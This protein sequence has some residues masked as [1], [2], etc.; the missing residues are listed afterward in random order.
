MDTSLL[1]RWR[2]QSRKIPT[3]TGTTAMTENAIA[4]VILL[5]VVVDGRLSGSCSGSI[6]TCESV[7]D[8]EMALG[9]VVG[10]VVVGS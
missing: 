6:P 2:H 9:R 10:L 1:F 8:D 4:V 5:L 3:M 7:G